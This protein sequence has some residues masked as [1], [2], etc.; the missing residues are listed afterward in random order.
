MVAIELQDLPD[1][2]TA[3]DECGPL[4][5]RLGSD[6]MR[7]KAEAVSGDPAECWR[8]L[9]DWITTGTLDDQFRTNKRKVIGT[10]LCVL[11][12]QL[13][14]F[15]EYLKANPDPYFASTSGVTMDERA[16]AVI[17]QLHGAGLAISAVPPMPVTGVA[18]QLLVR[19]VLPLLLKY[20]KAYMEEYFG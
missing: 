19:F 8:Q 4:I 6:S 14:A 12:D 5:A 16:D 15:S 9:W 7:L 18:W 2:E 1:L 11:A 13:A 10:I 17:G 20:L 3:L